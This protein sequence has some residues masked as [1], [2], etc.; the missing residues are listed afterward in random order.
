[1]KRYLL[2]TNVISEIR[3]RKPHGAVVEWLAGLRDDEICLSAVTLGELQRGV[4][5]TRRDNPG[6]ASEIGEWIDQVQAAYQVLPMDS[7]CFREWGRLIEGK[8]D[9]IAQDAMIA[10]TAR[11]HGLTVA[12]RDVHDFQPLHVP[13]FNPFVQV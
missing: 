10:A 9:Q 13:V 12:T 5:R 3:K 2:D 7:D 1:M 8:P 11:V 6:K 4:E